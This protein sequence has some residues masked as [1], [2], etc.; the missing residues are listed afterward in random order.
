M[1]AEGFG[2]SSPVMLRS[3][4]APDDPLGVA[5]N[6]FAASPT[7]PVTSNVSMPP[8]GLDGVTVRPS[9]FVELV[10][11]FRMSWDAFAAPFVDIATVVPPPPLG[12]AQFASPFACTPCAN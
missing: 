1:D 3:A 11:K 4:I 8:D 6:L 2:R 7:V 9:E 5:R 10:V 12:V